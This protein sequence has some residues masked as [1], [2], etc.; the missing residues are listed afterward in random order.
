MQESGKT[1]SPF[2]ETT[3]TQASTQ[4]TQTQISTQ[5]TQTHRKQQ[6]FNRQPNPASS[7]SIS[8]T[9]LSIIQDVTP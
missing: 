8:T 3:Q 7:S 2:T 9:G 1:P 6:A 5:M 4:T